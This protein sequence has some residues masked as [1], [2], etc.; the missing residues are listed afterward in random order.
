MNTKESE[1]CKKKCNNDSTKNNLTN[2][3][4]TKNNLTNNF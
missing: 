1:D 3:D 2:N 4:S